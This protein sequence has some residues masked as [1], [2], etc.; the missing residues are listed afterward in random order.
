MGSMGRPGRKAR[1]SAFEVDA[2]APVVVFSSTKFGIKAKGVPASRPLRRGEA[3]PEAARLL[4]P[5]LPRGPPATIEEERDDEADLEV[6][7]L[8]E[9]LKNSV[10]DVHASTLTGNARK[11]HILEKVIRLRGKAP[12]KPTEPTH[13]RIGRAAKEKRVQRETKAMARESDAVIAN[14]R[15]SRSRR[16]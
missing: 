13:I 6:G 11:R 2:D 15:T 8:W 12:K 9:R 5:A 14:T 3:L 16:K 7:E 1:E 4:Q 10:E